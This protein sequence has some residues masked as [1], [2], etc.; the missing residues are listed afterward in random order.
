MM[1]NFHETKERNVNYVNGWWIWFVGYSNIKIISYLLE[2]K[3]TTKT[4]KKLNE[5]GNYKN[6]FIEVKPDR[7]EQ[8]KDTYRYHN[9]LTICK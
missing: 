2:S 8:M 6:G 4:F 7:E 1:T 5:I 3:Y 9:E